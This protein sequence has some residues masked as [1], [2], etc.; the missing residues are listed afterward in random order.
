MKKRRQ[1]NEG[2]FFNETLDRVHEHL[3]EDPA[4]HVS[5]L[6]ERR[7]KGGKDEEKEREEEDEEKETAEDPAHRVSDLPVE[8]VEREGA[9]KERGRGRREEENKVKDRERSMKGNT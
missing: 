9:R 6:P 3:S 4:H 7:K 8:G 2:G 5:H 1:R